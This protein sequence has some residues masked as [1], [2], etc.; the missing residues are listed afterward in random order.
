MGCDSGPWLFA[1]RSLAILKSTAQM[2]MHHTDQV[3][4]VDCDKQGFPYKY[5][6]IDHCFT[7]LHMS[8]RTADIDTDEDIKLCG[9]IEG[10]LTG[11]QGFENFT[12]RHNLNA[13]VLSGIPGCHCATGSEVGQSIK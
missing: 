11:G 5:P 2:P 8:T 1:T 3:A 12:K 9:V 6:P 10:I 7:G 13:N 4:P